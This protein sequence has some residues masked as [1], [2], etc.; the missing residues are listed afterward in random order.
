VPITNIV[1]ND[2]HATRVLER[3][4]VFGAALAGRTGEAVELIGSYHPE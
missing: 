1:A 3:V 2:S 4:G